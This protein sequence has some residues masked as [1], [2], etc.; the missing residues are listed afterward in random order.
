M[1]SMESRSGGG[2]TVRGR[3][4]CNTVQTAYR[5][6]AIAQVA[7][8]APVGASPTPRLSSLVM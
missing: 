2:I 6:Q 4:S 8:C 5:P 3:C 1:T 7:G